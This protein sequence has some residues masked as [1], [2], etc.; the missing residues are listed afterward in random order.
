MHTHIPSRQQ[1]YAHTVKRIM[2]EAL[3]AALSAWL[4]TPT[5]FDI[6]CT[7]REASLYWDWESQLRGWAEQGYPSERLARDLHFARRN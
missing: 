7:P 6:D 4:R 5:Q 3:H 1:P 2:A